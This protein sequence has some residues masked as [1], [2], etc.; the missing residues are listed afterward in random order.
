VEIRRLAGARR[1]E[2]GREASKAESLTTKIKVNGAIN[3]KAIKPGTNS[4]LF[5]F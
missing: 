5:G 3:S 1:Y 4:W 2:I